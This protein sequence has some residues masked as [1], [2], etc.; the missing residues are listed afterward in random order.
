[1]IP[2]V[3]ASSIPSLD[4][5][6]ISNTISSSPTG[7]GRSLIPSS[8]PNI[9]PNLISNAPSS[10]LKCQDKDVSF[11]LPDGKRTNCVKA[12]RNRN[13]ICN[14]RI[15]QENCPR[16]CKVCPLCNDSVDKVFMGNEYGMKT[17]SFAQSNHN[18]CNIYSW[19]K[20]DCPLSCESCCKDQSGEI[21]LKENISDSITCEF[22][23]LAKNKKYCTWSRIK[24]S[25]P[26]SCDLC[27]TPAPVE[28]MIPDV[29][30]SSIPSLDPSSIL[31]FLPSLFLPP[32][33]PLER[34]QILRQLVDIEC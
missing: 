31:D 10:F 14:T 26:E 25:C 30:A 5:S 4:P 1:M 18:V 12:K 20:K 9:M 11:T 21:P 13:T 19:L 7:A 23:K 29:N 33:E 34:L 3:N 24:K 2:D 16:L 8:A 15:V 6:S 27:S 28:S 22:F 32:L 17:C